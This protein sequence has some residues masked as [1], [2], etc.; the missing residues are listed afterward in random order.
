MTKKIDLRVI[1]TK[2]N[3]YDAL[4]ILLKDF[5]F[6][7]IKVSDI[8]KKAMTNRSTFYDH[9]NDKY[10][11]LDSLIKDLELELIEKLDL[12]TNYSTDKEYYMKM[13]EL[14]FSHISENID[15]YSSIIKNNNNSIA[16]DMVMHTLYNDVL[17]NLSIHANYSGH[18]PLEIVTSFYVSAVANVCFFYLK[19]PIAYKKEDILSY[20]K[21][22]I[23]DNIY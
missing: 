5:T 7:D 6:E 15:I 17:K 10:E 13:L 14:L 8:C 12:N 1:K 9:F 2:K 20:L 11:L 22:L 18:I 3:L 16:F 19:D 23:P 4:M 21:E